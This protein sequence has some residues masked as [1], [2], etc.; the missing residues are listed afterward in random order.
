MQRSQ[1]YYSV[2]NSSKTVFIMKFGLVVAVFGLVAS[3]ATAVR[4]LEAGALQ[5][6]RISA[7]PKLEETVP[8]I[9]SDDRG[10]LY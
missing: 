5:L 10:H 1:L 3:V 6:Q 8:Y 7:V 4:P 2:T 9:E